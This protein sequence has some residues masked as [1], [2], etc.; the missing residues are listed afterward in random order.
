MIVEI[1]NENAFGARIEH[2]G[3]FSN[4]SLNEKGRSRF[5]VDRICCASEIPA[6]LSILE[7][8]VGVT[9]V[10]VNVTTKTVSGAVP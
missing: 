1:L 10:R 8:M 5:F 6:I 9:C 3:A 2:D 4:N 7:P